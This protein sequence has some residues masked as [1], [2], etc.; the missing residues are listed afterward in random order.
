MSDIATA[1]GGARYEGFAL[2]EEA[3]AGGMIA[4]RGDWADLGSALSAALPLEMPQTRHI[5]TDGERSLAWMSPDEAL[6]FLPVDEV[7]ETVR[8]ITESAGDA[9]VTAIDVSDMRAVFRISGEGTG[10]REVLSKLCPVDMRSIQVGELRRTR[11][12][13]VPAAFWIGSDGTITVICFRSV[14]AYAFEVLTRAARAGTEVGH[15]A[16]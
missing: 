3:Q 16:S 15:L 2:V 8:R 9:F 11:L 5:V 13:Q 7:A 4:L 6:V 12:S 10:P 1:L 14:A